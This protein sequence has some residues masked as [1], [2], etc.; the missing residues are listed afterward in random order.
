[1]TLNAARAPK[2]KCQVFYKHVI[3]LQKYINNMCVYK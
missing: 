3:K 1:M 2:Y